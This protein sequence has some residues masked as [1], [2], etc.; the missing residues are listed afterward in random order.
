MSNH[1][2]V[3]S[4][5][6]PLKSVVLKR[7][8]KE[9][10]NLIPDMMKELL[11]DD[12][13]YLPVM[14]QEHDAFAD[15]L[16]ENDVE[17]LYLEDLAAEAFT[18]CDKK[19]AFID[20]ML[21]ES[22]VTK[23]SIRRSL[24]DYFL[25]ME[26]LDMINKLIAGIHRNEVE[27]L[28]EADRKDLP[29]FLMKPMPNLYFT[30][31]I[32]SVVGTS[33]SI[34]SM[35]FEARSRETLFV[36]L[37]AKYHPEHKLDEADIL[38][39]RDEGDFS[40]EGGDIIVLS[41]K[42]VAIGISQRTNLDGAKAIAKKLF[43]QA[44]GFDHVLAIEIPN[45]RAMMHLDTVFTMID[46]NVFTMHAGI[47]NVDGSMTIHVIE[48]DE[49]DLSITVETDLMT[50]L[51]KSLKKDD[52][53]I[54]PCGNG[55]EIDGPREQWNDGSNTLAIAPGKVVTYDRNTVTNALLREH[56]IEVLE[57][58]AGELSRGRG[59]PRCMSLPLNR[60]RIL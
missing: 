39:N 1:L 41:D 13:P 19:E 44:D 6:E 43:K 25:N 49:D 23:D 53:V 31:D 46:T 11:F 30:R 2:N 32:A 26:P 37:I 9:I 47:Q 18:A 15:L 50:V 58:V 27:F 48:P 10:E 12:I 35:T 20:Q 7:P 22:R 36:E 38:M 21:T 29:L 52:I 60:K 56:G 42:V 51:K 5:I 59:G 54:I 57:I 28:E 3:Y 16:R 55:D 34:N 8:G 24:K 4:E 14:Q 40:T 17:V 45:V 33:M